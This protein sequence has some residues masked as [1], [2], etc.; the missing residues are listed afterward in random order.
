MQAIS[1]LESGA[2]SKRTWLLLAIALSVLLHALVLLI[3][4][5]PTSETKDST[6]LSILI[7]RPPAPAPKDTVSATPA[8]EAPV[9]DEPVVEPEKPAETEPPPRSAP[10][11]LIT[12][13]PE[14]AAADDTPATSPA[15]E[16]PLST[17]LLTRVR[18]NL[19][20]LEIPDAPDA[21][22]AAPVPSL[23]DAPGWI[24]QYIGTVDTRVEQWTNADGTRES[25][26][27][28]ASGQVFCGRARAPTTAE[29]FNPQFAMNI[30]LFRDCGRARPPPIDQTDPW[31]RAPRGESEN[32]RS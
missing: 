11:R 27:V 16:V 8:D 23:P 15:S 19:G 31:I 9:L 5:E 30:M 2:S 6:R 24:D 18:D 10:Q 4:R 22:T 29:L 14:P 17:R 32:D 1:D 12:R 26:I 25:R 3:P 28:T 13:R 21:L 20:N 7:E